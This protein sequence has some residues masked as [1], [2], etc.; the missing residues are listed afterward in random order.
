MKEKLDQHVENDQINVPLPYPEKNYIREFVTYFKIGDHRVLRNIKFCPK[1]FV[2]AMHLGCEMIMKKMKKNF[3]ANPLH[4]IASEGVAKILKERHFQFLMNGMDYNGEYG[5]FTDAGRALHHWISCQ[6]NL[7]W[8][9]K[10]LLD[11]SSFHL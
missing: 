5:N 10:Q 2:N 1:T 8:T 11:A 7:S 6:E 3:E 4:I 9:M